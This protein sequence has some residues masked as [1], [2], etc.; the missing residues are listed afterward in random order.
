MSLPFDLLA[1][2]LDLTLLNDDHQISARNMAA[3]GRC[4][5]LGVKVIITSG[6]MYRCTLPFVHML[7]LDT[8]VIAYN[9]AFIKEERSGN[10]LWHKH[11]DLAAAQSLVAY[12][13]AEELNLN[14]YLD[15]SLYIARMNPWAELY[16]ARTG[17]PL[18]IVGDLSIFADRAPTKALIVADPER[19][20]QL[21]EELSPRYAGQAYITISNIEYLEFM[22]LDANKGAAL[23]VVADYYGIAREKVLAFGDAN[24]DIPLIEWAGLGVAMD[25]ARPGAKAVADRIAPRY[26]EDGVAIVLEELFGFTSSRV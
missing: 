6:R 4:R 7:A 24:N 8:P 14:Y 21:Q 22:P 10:V 19:I 3:V 18:H 2:D 17:A 16:A 9:G 26:D 20:L 1:L 12:C 13:A 5:D 15:D 11:L 23:A 25:N